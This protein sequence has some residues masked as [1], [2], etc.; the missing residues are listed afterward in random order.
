MNNAEQYVIN[1]KPSALKE[2]KK[3]PSQQKARI[4]SAILALSTQPR[5]RGVRKLIQFEDVF[6]LRVGIYRV[7]F[8]IDDKKLVVRILE[9]K[10]RKNA[11]R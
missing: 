5:K 11:Y 9:I 3:F 6:R 10:H 1:I 7:F 8:Q 4:H 2:L